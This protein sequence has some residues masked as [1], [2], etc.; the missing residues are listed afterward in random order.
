MKTPHKNNLLNLLQIFCLSLILLACDQPAPP[1]EPIATTEQPSEETE[2]EKAPIPYEDYNDPEQWAEPRLQFTDYTDGITTVLSSK[3]DGSDVRMAFNYRDFRPEDGEMTSQVPVRSPNNRYLITA[4]KGGT[5]EDPVIV[6]VNLPEQSYKIIDTGYG[7]PMFTWSADSKTVY[8]YSSGKLKNYNLDSKKLTI[9]PKSILSG[10]LY[11]L[12]DQTS[13]LSVLSY[14]LA[15]YDIKTGRE[16]KDRIDLESSLTL[17]SGRF[18][19][20]KVS[21]LSPDQQ[22]FYFRNG[23]GKGVANIETG[24]VLFYIFDSDEPRVGDITS[25]LFLNN[26]ELIYIYRT[27][28]YKINIFTQERTKIPNSYFEGVDITLINKQKVK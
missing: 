6:I 3:I 4:L 11:L 25:A 1:A 9:L 10:K 19:E 28:L 15:T 13:F 26:K 23:Y 27:F 18:S 14:Y 16:I 24:K 22:H 5:E 20:I 12:K 21:D 8:F 2:P 7:V 17:A